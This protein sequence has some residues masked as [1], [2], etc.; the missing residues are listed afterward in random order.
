MFPGMKADP[1]QLEKLMKQFGVKTEQL[2]AKKAVFELEDG[3]RIVIEH[4]SIASMTMQ[5]KKTYTVMGEEKEEQQGIPEADIEMV[6]QQTKAS[7][8]KAQEAL[9]KNQGDIAKAIMELK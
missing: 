2:N 3:K 4:P 1:R 7:R 9:E 8:K 5:G 6:M